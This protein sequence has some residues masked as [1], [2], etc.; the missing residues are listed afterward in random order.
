MKNLTLVSATFLAASAA[1]TARMDHAMLHQPPECQLLS[2]CVS[3]AH[4]A[5][6]TSDRRKEERQQ[7][8]SS[9]EQV[10]ALLLRPRLTSAAVRAREPDSCWLCGALMPLR[11]A[12]QLQPPPHAILLLRCEGAFSW[13]T[14]RTHPL[15]GP[16]LRCLWRRPLLAG[17]GL[18]R[19]A[20]CK[21][22]GVDGWS[23]NES[24][25]RPKTARQHRRSSKSLP[26]SVAWLLRF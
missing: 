12:E 1:S 24:M 16:R 23:I 5:Q 2:W 21:Q 9:T 14:N 8:S 20:L 6:G 19:R 10:D 7:G 13:L 3:L 26:T 18:R 22:G 11:C 17:P 4:C 15:L 25:T